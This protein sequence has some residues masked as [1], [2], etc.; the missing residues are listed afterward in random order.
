MSVLLSDGLG[1]NTTTS[2][3][4]FGLDDL[5]I[6]VDFQVNLPE[7]QLKKTSFFIVYS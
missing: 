5:G 2:L 1:L 6:L 4:H 3:V 7:P